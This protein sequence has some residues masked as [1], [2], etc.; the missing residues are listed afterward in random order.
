MRASPSDSYI[1][2]QLK[3]LTQVSAFIDMCYLLCA[4]FRSTEACPGL[5][6]SAALILKDLFIHSWA[7]SDRWSL[8]LWD[9]VR[10]CRR[11]ALAPDASAAVPLS[12]V[13]R[14]TLF[15]FRLHSEF[16]PALLLVFPLLWA[17]PKPLKLPWDPIPT[18]GP[19]FESNIPPNDDV[20][21]SA[22]A[23][24]CPA[25]LPLSRSYDRGRG[26]RVDGWGSELH[27][28]RQ[29]FRGTPSC[30]GHDEKLFF[31]FFIC[32]THNIF[33]YLRD[34]YSVYWLLSDGQ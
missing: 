3:F 13:S 20:R 4:M 29:D 12:H 1:S 10:L 34:Y 27:G 2:P 21:L 9:S 18:F 24:F 16:S 8:L 26:L 19:L 14:S 22:V 23:I 25:F 28:R 5:G 30:E 6:D 33:G 11:N 17:G 31:Y 15:T 7:L 32:S